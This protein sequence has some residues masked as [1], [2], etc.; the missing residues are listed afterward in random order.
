MENAKNERFIKVV[1]VDGKLIHLRR[2]SGNLNPHIVYYPFLFLYRVFHHYFIFIS[3][4]IK[5]YKKRKGG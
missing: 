5:L 2:I 3:C 1:I 4:N